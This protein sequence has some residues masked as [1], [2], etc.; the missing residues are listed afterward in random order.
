V[1]VHTTHAEA[2]VF[3]CRSIWTPGNGIQIPGRLDLNH[4]ARVYT[5]IYNTGRVR[6]VELPGPAHVYLSRIFKLTSS[7]LRMQMLQQLYMDKGSSEATLTLE[8]VGPDSNQLTPSH[9]D[10][11][12]QRHGTLNLEPLPSQDPADPLNWPEWRVYHLFF[13]TGPCR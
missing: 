2:A 11:L 5:G 9:H 4:M 6:F 8:S 13:L 1:E 10:Y 7:S 3:G 12:L